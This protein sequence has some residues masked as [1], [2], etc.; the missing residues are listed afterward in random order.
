[1]KKALLFAAT[2]SLCLAADPFVGTWKAAQFDKWKI[3]PGGR[4]EERKS[5]I[6]T[7]TLVGKDT[8]HEIVANLD[9]KPMD[10]VPPY[11]YSLDGKEGKEGDLTSKFERTGERQNRR[12]VTGPKGTVIEEL[13]IS[14]D[15]KTATQT[16]KGA[17]TTSG[18]HVDERFIYEKV[19]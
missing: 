4:G 13:V 17:G 15:G 12:T 6:V 7:T 9:G 8:Y 5:W 10:G 3:S 14:S 1:M 19:K 16:R 18:R 11:T 2:A